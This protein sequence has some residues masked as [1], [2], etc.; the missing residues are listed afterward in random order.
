MRVLRICS[1]F[2][3]PPTALHG[4]GARFDPVG[5]MQTHTHELSKALDQLGVEQTILTTRPPTAAR[6]EALGAHGRIIRLGPPIRHFRQL[7]SWPAALLLPRLAASVDLVHVHLGED[8]AVVPLAMRAA[9]RHGLPL[10][11]TVHASVRHTLGAAGPRGWFLKHVGGHFERR[12]TQAAAAVIV[13]V[14]RLAALMNAEGA[15]AP[16]HVIPS[17]VVPDD[18]ENATPHAAMSA[19]PLPRVL[20]LVHLHVYKQVDVLVRAAASFPQA[21]VVLVGDGP[22]RGSLEHLARAGSGSRTAFISSGSCRTTTCPQSCGQQTCWSCHRSTKSSVPR[23]SRPCR[24]ES[25]SWRRT[26]AVSPT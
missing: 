13:L 23:C 21:Q 11:M 6:D 7:Y 10:V 26:P 25:P 18:F 1:V 3:P 4:R 9:R 17:G 14:P 16:V 8:I 24:W 19:I 2:Q 15:R 20:F 5:G 22:E 12:G